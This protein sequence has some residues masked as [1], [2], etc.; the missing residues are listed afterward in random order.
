MVVLGS[1]ISALTPIVPLLDNKLHFF[2]GG[3][4]GEL[5]AANDTLA[6]IC[7]LLTGVF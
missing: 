3:H 6:W 7:L 2:D 1:V 4:D 5:R